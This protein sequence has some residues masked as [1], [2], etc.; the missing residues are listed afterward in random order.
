MTGN[1]NAWRAPL[2]GLASL[3]MIATMGVAASTANAGTAPDQVTVTYKATQGGAVSGTTTQNVT[4]GNTLADQERGSSQAVVTPDTAAGYQFVG[5]GGFNFDQPLTSDQTVTAVFSTDYTSV[6]FENADGTAYT[7]GQFREGNV[8]DGTIYVQKSNGVL[9]ATRVPVDIAGDHAIVTDWTVTVDG[10]DKGTV[11]TASLLKDGYKIG[12]AKS[13]AVFKAKTVA[14]AYTVTFNQVAQAGS[15]IVGAWADGV[16]DGNFQADIAADGPAV[17]APAVVYAAGADNSKVY[18]SW[19]YGNNNS[20]AVGAQLAAS[21]ITGDTA[22]TAAEPTVTTQYKVE[23]DSKGGSAV[24]TQYV[25]EGK[26]VTKPENPTL[27]GQV[28]KGWKATDASYNSDRDGFFDW[29][30]PVTE[31]LTLEAEWAVTDTITVTFHAGDYKDAPKDET[32][33][34]AGDGFVDESKAPKFTREGYT[35]SSWFVDKNNNGTQNAGEDVFDF[36]TDLAGEANDG[37]DFTLVPVWSA[38]DENDAKAA[39]AYVSTGIDKDGKVSDAAKRD[40]STYFTG[41]SWEKFAAVYKT[42]YQKYVSAKYTSDGGV[43]KNEISAATSAEIVN[44]L[45]DAWKGLRFD[46]AS[47]DSKLDNANA[48][49]AAADLVY[50]LTT[51]DGHH[52]LLTSDEKEVKQLTNK[53]QSFGGWN[54]DANTFRVINQYNTNYTQLSTWKD[55][56]FGVKLIK[57]VTRFYNAA[58]QEHL[59]TSDDDEKAALLAAGWSQDSEAASFYIPAQYQGST[60]VVRLYNPSIRQ[61]LFTSDSNEVSTL[62]RN[63]WTKDSDKS[64]IYAL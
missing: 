4:Y 23:F 9:D 41:A 20:V 37:N 29:T 51:P 45:K 10:V 32:L 33:T 17:I 26:F 42:Q 39:L 57:N 1:K 47:V 58:V 61:H 62:L 50:R 14:T 24:A 44:A 56:L 15:T 46:S 2:A 38:V 7:G 40:D 11:T 52:H 49:S 55:G 64:T 28:F 60:P 13:G 19:T 35:Y 25:T 31:D 54:L 43:N 6:K 36:T 59:Y 12:R 48:K 30:K 53:Y 18:N 27:K 3:A 22:L 21:A 63:G 5:F 16:K 34:V 8:T